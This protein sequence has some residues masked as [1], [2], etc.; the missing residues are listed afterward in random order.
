MS[1]RK[2][3]PTTWKVI[4]LK[5]AR[6]FGTKRNVDTHGYDFK[7]NRIIAEVKHR[8]AMPAWIEDAWKQIK[9]EYDL[10]WRIN[11]ARKGTPVVFLHKKGQ[12]IDRTWVLTQ[13]KYLKELLD[14]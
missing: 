5:L 11:H 6:M 12:P 10:D 13:A 14:D 4:E 7:T 9:A 3:P 2:K 8:K 1:P